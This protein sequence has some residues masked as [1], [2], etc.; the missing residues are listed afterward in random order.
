MSEFVG[1]NTAAATRLCATMKSAADTASRL[2][3]A[4]SGGIAAAGAAFPSG[5]KGAEVVGQCGSFLTDSERDLKW[6][7][8][9]IQSVPGARR[10][11]DDFRVAEFPYDSQDAA[12]R[13][14]EAEG[15]KIKDAWA[16][17]EKDQ[18]YHTFA[19]LVEALKAGKDRMGDPAYA[20]GFLGKLTPGT[21]LDIVEKWMEF[22]KDKY[23]KGLTPKEMERFREDLG[24]LAQALASADTAGLVPDLRKYLV[25]TSGPDVMTALLGAAPQ[26]KQFVVEAGRYLAAAVT[27]HTGPNDNWQLYWF[28]KA[29]DGNPE[30]FQAILATDQRTADL[31]LRGEVL[32]EG[33][34]P[35]LEALVTGAIAKAL[36]G[37]VPGADRRKA[38]AHV[39]GAYTKAFADDPVLKQALVDALKRELGDPA[40]GREAFQALAKALAARGLKPEALKDADINAVVA[41]HAARWLPEIAGLTAS[42]NDPELK[43]LDPG[44]GWD[45]LSEQDLTNLFAGIFQRAEGRQP[46]SDGMRRFQNSLDM[47]GGDLDNPEDRRK[48]THSMA[49]IGA[50]GGLMVGAVHDIDLSEEERRKLT[51]EMLVLPIDLAIGRAG[52]LVPGEVSSTVW[53]NFLENAAKW[54][55]AGKLAK[56]L[57]KEDNWFSKLPVIGGLFGGGANGEAS[58]LVKELTEQHMKS[59][60]DRLKAAGRPP[61]SPDDRVLLENAIQGFYLETVV[62][63]LKK[64]GG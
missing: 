23:G 53:K 41:G 11:S 21:Y 38:V 27:G 13:A 57:D 10:V 40:T 33:R 55:V 4:L 16:A 56:E 29:L 39:A 9:T 37:G 42:R 54:P 30:A 36:A 34:P 64:R 18:S 35:G 62:K 43:A 17:Y 8:Q 50:L 25:E 2:R 44:K 60:E 47:G 61:L 59:Y 24:G 20:A 63:A 46:L 26:S 48:F 31:I 32:H 5:A 3:Q 1:L 19:D 49:Q 6:R 15:Q 7:V 22:N 52:K 28:F 58:D 12:R 14:G 51:V 45:R